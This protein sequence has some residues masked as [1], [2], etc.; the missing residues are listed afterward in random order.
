MARTAQIELV[1]RVTLAGILETGART[2]A[3]DSPYL[4]DK[5]MGPFV[6]GDLHLLR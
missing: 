6:V 4:P 5:Q 3:E 2:A 1:L